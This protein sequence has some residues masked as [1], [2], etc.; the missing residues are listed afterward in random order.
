MD[1]STAPNGEQFP[2]PAPEDY[3]REIS[4]LQQLCKAQQDQGRQVVVVMGVGFVGAVMAGVVADAWNK[5]TNDS[6]YF[7]IG[8]QRP[9]PRSFWKIPM[10]NRGLAPPNTWPIL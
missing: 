4:R 9:S 2:L 3:D 6:P 5:D 7:V 8:M 1:I 10:L